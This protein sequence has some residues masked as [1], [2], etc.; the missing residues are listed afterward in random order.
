MA[1]GVG[2]KLWA[3]VELSF[4][5]ARHMLIEWLV[6][7]TRKK[8]V[9]SERQSITM[10]VTM[11]KVEMKALDSCLLLEVASTN[12]RGDWWQQHPTH[13]SVNYDS[14]LAS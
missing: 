5:R 12:H 13:I 11:E 3:F 8:N 6:P 2:E 14:Q 1:P 9:T 4:R 7:E 10:E